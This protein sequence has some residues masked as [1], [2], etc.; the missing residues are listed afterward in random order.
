MPANMSTGSACALRKRSAGNQHISR[1][2]PHAQGCTGGRPIDH[3]PAHF[4]NSACGL[5]LP[6][7]AAPQGLPPSKAHGN[8]MICD[9]KEGWAA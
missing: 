6:P 4:H 5:P 9:W 3:L 2:A 7:G 1:E 8:G